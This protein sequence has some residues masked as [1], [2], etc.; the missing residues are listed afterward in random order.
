MEFFV[1][2]SIEENGKIDCFMLKPSIYD[3]DTKRLQISDR[4]IRFSKWESVTHVKTMEVKKILENK[5]QGILEFTDGTIGAIEDYVSNKPLL[6]DNWFYLATLDIYYKVID[7][8][9]LNY[10]NSGFL[11][12]LNKKI[13]INNTTSLVLYNKNIGVVEKDEHE[14]AV[15]S[16]FYVRLLYPLGQDE[17]AELQ[18]ALEE[19]NKYKDIIKNLMSYYDV[20]ASKEAYHKYLNISGRVKNIFTAMGKEYIT[21]PEGVILDSEYSTIEDLL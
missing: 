14:E 19:K 10:E 16:H 17:V 11:F 20:D 18:S 15:L 9:E 13:T 4:N 3:V 5:E 12:K 6:L 21:L 2:T 1:K 8:S 7:N